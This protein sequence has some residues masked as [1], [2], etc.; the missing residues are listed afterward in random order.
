M[1]NTKD[2]DSIRRK[3]LDIWDRIENRFEIT[4]FLGEGSF[5]QVKQAKCRKTGKNVA[6]KL[7][8]NVGSDAKSAKEVIREI[9]ILK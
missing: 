8:K 5:G 1:N 9:E 6:I 3:Y 2:K 7:I 4:K